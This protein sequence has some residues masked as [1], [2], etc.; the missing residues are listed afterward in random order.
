[1]KLVYENECVEIFVDETKKLVVQRWGEKYAQYAPFKEAIDKT[2]EIFKSGANQL[3]LS[4]TRFQPIVGNEA[5]DYA[6]SMV[7][8]LCQNGMK[9]MA[10]LMSKDILVKLGV[11]NFTSAANMPPFIKHFDNEADANKWFFEP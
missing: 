1:M 3:L 7:P 4:D 10:F 8:T 6:A 2:V 9:K 5:T 11:K